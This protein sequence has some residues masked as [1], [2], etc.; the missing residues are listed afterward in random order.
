MA[1]QGLK[2]CWALPLVLALGLL[3]LFTFKTNTPEQTDVKLVPASWLMGDV[4]L[5]Q[6][7]KK[8]IR[9]KN[10]SLFPLEIV[11][12][13]PSCE[14]IIAEIKKPM[15]FLDSDAII[16]VSIE[17]KRSLGTNFNAFVYIHAQEPATDSDS[18]T[19]VSTW[20]YDFENRQVA[21]SDPLNSGQY[22]YDAGG[23]RIKKMATITTYKS[24][25]TQNAADKIGVGNGK[26]QGQNNGQ[27]IQNAQQ[28]M[29]ETTTNNERYFYDG[30]NIVADYNNDGILQAI[31]V[32]PFLD[33]NLVKMITGTK[34]Y[35]MHDGLGS[36][37]CLLNSS[38]AIQ[39]TYEYTAFGESL[40]WLESIQNRYTY[41]GREWDK[42]SQAY[43]YRIRQYDSRSARF[44][45][46]DPVSYFAG[47]NVY[48]YVQNNST[49]MIDSFGLDLDAP[50]I[51]R[52]AIFDK[53]E[54][55]CW[56]DI[57]AKIITDAK[58]VTATKFF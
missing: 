24:G 25:G 20:T 26:G 48:T 47:I 9:I 52:Q 51:L 13:R 10:N 44:T 6:E 27:G 53:N 4:V 28:N 15:A 22:W 45:R 11:K 37:R 12:V 21:Y 32:M 49:N 54:K 16:A 46:R 50:R 38:Q 1:L 55:K 40:N 57:I 8:E 33:Q 5:G 41:T 56:I 23:R 43:Y 3:A 14:C 17:I 19:E 39:N 34:Y 30:A 58:A 18:G 35:Y 2:K 42:E 31:Y 29:T 7:Y 36:A